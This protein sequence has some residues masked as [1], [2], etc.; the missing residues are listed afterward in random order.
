MAPISINS[1]VHGHSEL[2]KHA[3]E[4]DKVAHVSLHIW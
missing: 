1:S 4:S 2:K 3:K